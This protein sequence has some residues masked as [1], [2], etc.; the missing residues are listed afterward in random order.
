MEHGT[1]PKIILIAIALAVVIVL[2]SL[3]QYRSLSFGLN[4][5]REGFFIAE[6]VLTAPFHFAGGLWT[7]YVAL[8]NI[9]AENKELKKRLDQLQVQSMTAQELKSENGRLRTM[10]DFK[11]EHSDLKLFP[12]RLL[13]QDITN[14]FKSVVIDRGKTSGFFIDMP[15]VSPLGL[16]GRAIAV[17]THTSQI[18][19]VT[20]PN[21]A[22]P[23]IIEETRVKG[24]V[25]GMGTNVLSLEYV[26]NTELVSVGNMVVTSGLEGIFPKGLRIGRIA[27]VKRD[28]HKIF[29]KITISPSVEMSKI[30]GVFGVG[31]HASDAD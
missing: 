1:T 11:N 25:K 8:V 21:S 27:E 31:F 10:L 28:P 14:V 9:R 24:I 18:L 29:I 3:G 19:L 23:A 12:A 5:V 2:L 20:D 6:K 17:S 22:V 4:P 13:S 30:E 16:V 15:V 7:D 26:R